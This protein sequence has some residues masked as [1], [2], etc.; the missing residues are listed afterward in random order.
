MLKRITE[1]DTDLLI[2]LNNLGSEHQDLFWLLVTRIIFWIPLYIFFF[3]LVFRKNSRRE[4][5]RVVYT[6]VAMLAATFGLTQ[7][8]KNFVLR[9]RPVNNERVFESLRVMIQPVDYSFFSGHA[10][11]SFAI[12]TLFYLFLRK[13]IPFAW[14]FYLW[15]CI[16]SY[17]RIYLGVHF[18]S[19]VFVG[20]IV[21]ITMAIFFYWLHKMLTI[22]IDKKNLQ[23]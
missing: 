3:Y 8:V 17:S 1:Y 11:N 21:G 13:K 15:P 22:R 4:A 19:D 5:F 20:A 7:L 6:L 16:F 9:A 2:Y 14:T 10:C 23:A 18:P 12:T